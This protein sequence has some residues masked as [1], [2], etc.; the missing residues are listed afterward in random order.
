MEISHV[1]QIVK[2]I[3]DNSFKFICNQHFVYRG[4]SRMKYS[5]LPS[6]FRKRDGNNGEEIYLSKNSER[7]ILTEF[8][9]ESASFIDNL[10]IDD[11]FRWVEY[12]QHFGA[13]TRLMDWTSNPLVAL[14][15]ACA[16]HPGED[17]RV[18]IL[19]SRGYHLLT[20][21]KNIN[22]M[23]GKTIKDEAR[24]MIWESDDT[25]PYPVLFKPYYL[26]RRMQAQSSQFMVWG[27]KK[28]TLNE[29][30]G[31]L[32]KNGK[33]KERVKQTD[34]SGLEYEYLEDIEVLSEIHIKGANK[35]R[36]QRE[37]DS[38]GINYATLFPG[39]D[40][41]GKSVEWRNKSFS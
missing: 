8:M 6:V 18:Y 40:G 37:L 28:K 5:L 35:A 25:F 30:M 33:K 32:E 24:K 14:Y 36:L 38:I 12:A 21:E 20:G 7:K 27:Y 3:E 39:L 2:I 34:D 16:S 29:L 26:D 9:T 10:S 19:N 17:G 4:E 13:P 22:Q 23:D 11:L 31:E 1:S 15:F 41:I